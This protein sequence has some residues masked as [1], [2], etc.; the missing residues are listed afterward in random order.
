MAPMDNGMEKYLFSRADAFGIPLKTTL[1]LTPL[2]NLSCRM[3][4]LRHTASEV[5]EKGGLLP[6]EFW[7]DLIP[8]LQKA[9]TL[10]VALLGGEIFT[11]PWRGDLDT[12]LYEPGF[13]INLP[14]NAILLSEDLP[15]W[16]KKDK[17]RYVT[18]SLYGASDESYEKLTGCRNGFSK[19]TAGVENLIRAGIPTRLNC[20]VLPENAE[21][22][23]EM[24]HFSKEYGLPVLTTAYS[25][26]NGVRNNCSGYARFDPETAARTEFQMRKLTA[27]PEAFANWVKWLRTPT[28]LKTESSAL[29]TSHFTCRAAVSTAWVSWE[30]KLSAC[31]ML[32]EPSADLK[33]G[34]SFDDAWQLLKERTRAVELTGE[35]ARCQSRKICSVCPAMIFSETGSFAGTPRYLCRF[36]EELRRLARNEY[37]FDFP[38]EIS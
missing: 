6:K 15:G 8:E 12:K 13:Y 25:F 38:E 30:G 28:D 18:V 26:P 10:F 3:C 11:L 27:A 35:C 1:E 14:T 19:M 21:E 23:E 32:E 20:M 16:L 24:A 31:G 4:Y 36:T 33:D 2:C 9:E 5:K 34:H 37:G 22:I 7:L 29:R 17:P